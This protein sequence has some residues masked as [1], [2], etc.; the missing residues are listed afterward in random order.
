MVLKTKKN[1]QNVATHTL[2]KHSYNDKKTSLDLQPPFTHAQQPN[3]NTVDVIQP[4]IVAIP[5]YRRPELILRATLWTLF[6]GRITNHNVYIFV[7]N[8]NERKT[9]AGAMHDPIASNGRIAALLPKSVSEEQIDRYA[10]WLLGVQLIVGHK[11]LDKQ[12]NF[13]TSYFPDGQHIL[14]MDDDVRQVMRLRVSKSNPRDRRYWRLEV[15]TGSVNNKSNLDTLIQ[16]GFKKAIEAGAYL[17]GVYPVDNAYFMSPN[18]STRLKFIVGP[19]FG[20]I[21]R[22]NLSSRLNVTM[23]EKEDMERTL[24]YWREDGVVVR[25]NY[26]TVQTAY[27]NNAGGMQNSISIGEPLET[28]KNASIASAQQLHTMFP[29]LTKIFYRKSGPRKG[30]AEIRLVGSR[31]A[32]QTHK[33]ASSGVG[34][35]YAPKYKRKRKGFRMTKK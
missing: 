5:S 21:N 33:A 7:A 16:T 9:Y 10:K 13:I 23:D 11:G 2:K 18:S 4:Y 22:P 17:W 20:I 27:Y 3:N 34:D 29:K 15:V 31:P 12:R 24:R 35:S 8:V 30:W 28:R 19:M 14:N 32:K 26:I 25:L 1:R 6:R